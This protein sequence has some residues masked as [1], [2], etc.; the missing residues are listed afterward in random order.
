MQTANSTTQSWRATHPSEAVAWMSSVTVP[1]WFAGG[2][3]LDLFLGSP[4]RPHKDLDI[5]ILRRDLPKVLSA[6]SSWEVFEANNHTLTRLQAETASAD[7]HSLWC[8]PAGTTLWMFEL[9]L[10]ESRDGRWVFRRQPEIR[11]DL[12]TVIRRSVEGLPFL[13][14]D[15]QLLY[16]AR[17][18]R[19]EDQADFDRVAPR[20]DREARAWLRDALELVEPGHQWLA[21]LESPF[22]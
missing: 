10:D 6:L 15:I 16:K 14:P 3:A 12:E 5:G 13:A 9:M 8:R 2:W 17:S 7:V 4:S 1:W 11:R 21:A 18:V 19:A 20:L 22:V